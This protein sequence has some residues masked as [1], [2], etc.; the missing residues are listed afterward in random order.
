MLFFFF[1][2]CAVSSFVFRALIN[3]KKKIS[4]ERRETEG[5]E[6]G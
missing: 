5:L 4:G 2:P 1:F 6:I 3:G